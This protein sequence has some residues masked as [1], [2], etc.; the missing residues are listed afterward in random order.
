MGLLNR[1]VTPSKCLPDKNLLTSDLKKHSVEIHPK[2]KKSKIFGGPQVELS[3]GLTIESFRNDK[4]V[5][6]V[7]NNFDSIDI[8][9]ESAIEAQQSIK[10]EISDEINAKEYQTAID[11]STIDPLEFQIEDIKVGIVEKE[12]AII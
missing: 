3:E 12:Q 9:E 7:P 1:N 5:I 11:S 8:L 4:K 2:S 6:N 10:L